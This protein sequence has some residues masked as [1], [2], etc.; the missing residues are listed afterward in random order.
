MP[1]RKIAAVLMAL[2]A[3]LPAAAGPS[4]A[5]PALAVEVLY[6]PEGGPDRFRTDF[7]DELLLNL[8]SRG[9]FEAILAGGEG[10]DVLFRVVLEAP[11]EEELNTLSLAGSIR[12]EDEMGTSSTTSSIRIHADMEIVLTASGELFRSKRIRGQASYQSTFAWE[13]GSVESRDDL[14]RDFAAQMA[15]YACKANGKK[16]RKKLAGKGSEPPPIR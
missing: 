1:G 2:T 4:P 9:C 5:G 12:N 11:L 14:I 15:G 8:R 10:G 16:L 13:D 6:G 3:I 7:E